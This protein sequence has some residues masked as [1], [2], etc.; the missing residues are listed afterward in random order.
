MKLDVR[1]VHFNHLNGNPET[2]CLRVVDSTAHE[3][4]SVHILLHPWTRAILCMA[5]MQKAGA[6]HPVS[7]EIMV[8]TRPDHGVLLITM[9]FEQ[10]T[11]TNRSESQQAALPSR[12]H[13]WALRDFTATYGRGI[14]THGAVATV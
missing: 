7:A 11:C 3:I 12:A 2:D 9:M 13:H 8:S 5:S 14:E 10:N 1:H 4:L 6:L